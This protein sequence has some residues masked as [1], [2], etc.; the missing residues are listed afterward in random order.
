MM[1]YLFRWMNDALGYYFVTF[2]LL[3]CDGRCG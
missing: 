3:C 1:E 2:D